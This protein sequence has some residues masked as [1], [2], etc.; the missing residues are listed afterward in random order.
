[1]LLTSQR[2][3]EI[4]ATPPQISDNVET[5]RQII[6]KQ[7]QREVSHN[8]AQEIARSLIEFFQVLAEVN[9]EPEA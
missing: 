5:L 7:E 4:A 8:E 9:D 3:E 6:A 2:Q 1:M